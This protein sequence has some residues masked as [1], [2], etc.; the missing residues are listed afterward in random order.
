MF[1]RNIISEASDQRELDILLNSEEYIF[2]G[3][4]RE[5]KNL[6]KKLVMIK[7]SM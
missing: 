4:L 7:K 3:T 2:H 1:E 5:L 6:Q